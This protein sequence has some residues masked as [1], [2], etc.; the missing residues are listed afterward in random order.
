MWM[1]LTLPLDWIVDSDDGDNSNDDEE[2]EVNEDDIIEDVLRIVRE[3]KAQKEQPIKHRKVSEDKPAERAKQD[4]PMVSHFRLWIYNQLIID[5]TG[6]SVFV[7]WSECC[8]VKT[9]STS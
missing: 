1:C 2:D 5:I 8:S 4:S 3:L 7:L 6:H 9:T